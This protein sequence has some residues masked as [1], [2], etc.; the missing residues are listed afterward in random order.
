MAAL[1]GAERFVLGAPW[2]MLAFMSL[3]PALKSA[4]HPLARQVRLLA[5]GS[6]ERRD[7]GLFLVEGLR[8]LDEA[9]LAGSEMVW[10]L[11][12]AG[13]A[14]Q[15]K[16]ATMVRRASSAGIPVQPVQEKLL[17]RIAPSDTGPGLLAACRLPAD[18]NGWSELIASS[19]GDI[20]PVAWGVQNPGNLGTLMRSAAAF[21]LRAFLSVA[22]ADP[23][24]PKAVR[25]S[26]GTIHRMKVARAAEGDG[27]LDALEGNGFGLVSAVARGGQD[28]RSF[29]YDD[30]TALI[31]GS[32][33]SGLPAEVEERAT[34]LT[35]PIASNVE[36]LSVAA[37]GSILFF[38]A[39]RSL[40]R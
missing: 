2:D 40:P 22:G 1:D 28:P 23:W 29:S 36:S 32:E 6:Q 7:A 38:L 30:S 20:L 5:K 16:I 17:G 12:A 10:V 25:A 3:P 8:G 4:S 15:P 39:S 18:A 21:G 37:A 26:A 33:A 9:L 11:V 24:N 34:P 14:S 35:I 19:T 31:L 13:R 27:I